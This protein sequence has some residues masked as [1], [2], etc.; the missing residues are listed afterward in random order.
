MPSNSL[1]EAAQES[2]PIPCS[3]DGPCAGYKTQPGCPS[4][5]VLATLDKAKKELAAL[6]QGAAA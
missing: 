4:L 3:C 6:L 2:L 1:P 5:L